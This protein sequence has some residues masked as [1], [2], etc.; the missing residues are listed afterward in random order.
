MARAGSGFCGMFHMQSSFFY[1]QIWLVCRVCPLW[2]LIFIHE[3]VVMRYLISISTSLVWWLWKKTTLYD[4]VTS[5][6]V[7]L[8]A[9]NFNG[10]CREI[11]QVAEYINAKF[12]PVKD[13][14]TC[15]MIH[16][17]LW[18]SFLETLQASANYVF[19][20][21]FQFLQISYFKEHPSTAA[22]MFPL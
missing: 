12:Q 4:D 16:L 14:V 5:E 7:L 17:N 18:K 22:L 3:F 20:W 9:F 2:M 10:N 13:Y 21:N 8:W 6:P 1:L 11:I 15:Y 19:L